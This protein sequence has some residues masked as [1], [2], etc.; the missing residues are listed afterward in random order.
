[1]KVGTHLLVVAMGAAVFVLL[2][3][4]FLW[5]QLATIV[6]GLA[7]GTITVQVMWDEFRF[8]ARAGSQVERP[9][10]PSH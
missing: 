8:G 5:F 1:M 9:E 10:R 6:L 4:S 7:S 3:P 2:R